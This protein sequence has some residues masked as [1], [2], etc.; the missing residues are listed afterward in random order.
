MS[1]VARRLRQAAQI[2]AVG[3]NRVDIVVAVAIA[4]KRDAVAFR[5]PRGEVLMTCSLGQDRHDT[6]FDVD[7]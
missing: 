6:C 1:I 5:R 7:K 4:G 2:G 3:S